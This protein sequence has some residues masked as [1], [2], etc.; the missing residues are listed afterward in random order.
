MHPQ[1]AAVLAQAQR[2][3]S[4]MDD[5]LDR[6]NSQTFTA[7][8]ESGTVE[9]TL[10]GHHQLRAV[11]FVEGLIG[12]GAEELEHRLNE[13]LRNAA[14]AASASLDADR[15]RIDTMVAEVAGN[16]SEFA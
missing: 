7:T 16:A 13:A 9:V 12:V 15:E 5:Q 11:H 1:V 14:A 6:M 2:L 8:D 3:Q 4:I 10:D